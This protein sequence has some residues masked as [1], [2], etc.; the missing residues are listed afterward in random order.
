MILYIK[1][2]ND[3]K[4]PKDD[5]NSSSS[6][7]GSDSGSGSGNDHH[8][9][10]PDDNSTNTNISPDNNNTKPSTSNSDNNSTSGDDGGDDD[11]G[12]GDCS[13]KDCDL[14]ALNDVSSDFWDKVKGGFDDLNGV[15]TNSKGEIENI[16]N[17]INGKGISSFKGSCSVYSDCSLTFDFELAKGGK[18]RVNLCEYVSGFYHVLYLI[19]YFTFIIFF[20]IFSFKIIRG[21]F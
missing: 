7:S 8:I 1:K 5:D 10:K 21:L 19:F 20:T 17:T 2:D 9:N 6:N 18:I 13:G 15:Y 12:S 14:D 3:L 11:S 16:I 4:P